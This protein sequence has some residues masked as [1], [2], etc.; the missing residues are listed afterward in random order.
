MNLQ[1]LR[2]FRTIAEYQHFTKAV[3]AL[4]VNQSSLSHAMDSLET[5]LGAKLF[6][7]SGR[8]TVLSQYGRMFL[9]HVEKTLS[10]LETGIRELQAAAETEAGLVSVGSFQSLSGFIS[11]TIVRF[12]SEEKT[13]NIRFQ[14]TQCESH[15]SLVDQLI[16]GGVNFAIGTDTAEPGIG[17][18]YI[19]DQ[20]Y[21]LLAPNGHRLAQ[22]SSVSLR[23]LDGEDYIA[24]GKGSQVR[25][26]TDRLFRQL[27]VRPKIVAES[28]ESIMING[29]V[30]AGRG[31]AVAPS[32]PDSAY[33]NAVA[34]PITG[35]DSRKLHL[36]W[37]KKTKD[38]A[39]AKQFREYII[40]NG[41][42]FNEYRQRN[43]II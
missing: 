21:V 1:Q 33:Y 30:A 29:L 16:S 35:L 18:V 6:V 38:S 23:D 40:K 26:Q 43:H 31:I 27:G 32:P 3:A 20:S 15:E 5:Q 37:N 17:S 19:G 11:D 41:A 9:P 2:Y 8:N 12:I 13:S 28:S 24:F 14:V 34:V 36:L 22:R 42:V 39:S 10:A 25:R 4:S 7:R